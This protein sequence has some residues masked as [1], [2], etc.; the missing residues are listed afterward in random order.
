MVAGNLSKI[1]GSAGIPCTKERP[2]SPLTTFFK[3]TNTV[4]EQVYSKPNS[5]ITL[6]ISA[7]S[8]SGL[9]II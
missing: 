1:R 5:L 7:G 4:L 3:K 9:I 8:D 6:S 2:K